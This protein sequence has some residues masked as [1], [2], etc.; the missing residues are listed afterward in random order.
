MG[1]PRGRATYSFTPV[2]RARSDQADAI[3]QGAS[4]DDP[5]VPPPPALTAG[6]PVDVALIPNLKKDLTILTKLARKLRGKRED[7][8]G[9]VDLSSGERGSELKF[10]LDS[11]GNPVRV[12]AKTEKEIHHTIAEMMIFA[13]SCVASRI[14]ESFPETALLRI[15]RSVEEGRFE[16]LERVQQAVQVIHV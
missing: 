8:G 4:P 10:V 2:A 5:A 14:H 9:A 6:S 1:A 13:N 3:L 15:H 7:I 12:A 16:E 11:N